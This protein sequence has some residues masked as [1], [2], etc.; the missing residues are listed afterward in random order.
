MAKNVLRRRRLGPSALLANP[1]IAEFQKSRHV[2]NPRR[3]RPRTGFPLYRDDP[4]GAVVGVIERRWNDA[5]AW[6]ACAAALSLPTD[7]LLR[8]ERNRRHGG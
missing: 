7:A 8:L 6:C 2:K 1:L 4:F 5:A 3:V